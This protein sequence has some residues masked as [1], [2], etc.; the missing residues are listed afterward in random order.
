VFARRPDDPGIDETVGDAVI[1]ALNDRET[2][3]QEA[4][5]WALGTM[6]YERA[7]KGLN[8]LFQYHQRGPLAAAA[9]DAL[10]HIGHPSSV[11]QFLAQLN[12][13]NPTFKLIA[14]EG[15]GRTGDRSHTESVINAVASE[16]SDAI[17]LAGHFANV[18]L[19]DGKV[20]ALVDALT[21]GRLRDQA[22]GY[23]Q[24]IAVARS[25][26]LARY[27]QDPDAKVRLEIIDAIGLSGDASAQSLIEPL[28]RDRDPEVA[29][30][31]TRAIARLRGART[32]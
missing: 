4:A 20:D 22:L 10:A 25:Q 32:S 7:I 30:A 26:V 18:R 6:R 23:I 14:I 15:L 8:E 1:M 2:T 19:A 29:K 17:V 28:V 21:R 12:G 27:L 16:R 9:L 5:M 3:I 11:P 13:R 31:A 24:E